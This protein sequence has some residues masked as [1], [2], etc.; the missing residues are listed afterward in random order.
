MGNTLAYLNP[1]VAICGDCEATVAYSLIYFSA[2]FNHIQ[3]IPPS[4]PV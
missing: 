3:S 4:L 2:T 1:F